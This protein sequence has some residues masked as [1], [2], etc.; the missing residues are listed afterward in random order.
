MTPFFYKLGLFFIRVFFFFLGGGGGGGGA[1]KATAWLLK[2]PTGNALRLI[3]FPGTHVWN[4]NELRVFGST[5]RE[6]APWENPLR[7]KPKK[8]QTHRDKAL[9]GQAPKRTILSSTPRYQSQGCYMQSIQPMAM[10][11]NCIL[12]Q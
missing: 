6:R 3:K 11:P 2:A 7:G 1:P 10:I 9:R 12:D 8:R 4:S 5:H